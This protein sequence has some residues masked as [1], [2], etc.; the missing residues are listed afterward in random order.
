[1][2]ICKNEFSGIFHSN[3]SL[4]IPHASNEAQG[5]YQC[6]ATIGSVGLMASRK[7]KVQVAGLVPS[8]ET[9][10]QDLRVFPHQTA[11][12]SC[13][14]N[15]P[16]KYS[17]VWLKDEKP[18]SMD[19]S[20]MVLMPSGSLE[21]DE[22]EF[23]DQGS[24]RCNASS[25]GIFKLSNKAVLTMDTDLGMH[26]SSNVMAPIFITKP[27]SMVV[28]EGETIVLDCAAN[29]YP[30]PWLIWL[31]DGV[32]I[33]MAE[34][35]SRVFK[36]GSGSLKI[37]NVTEKDSGNYQCRAENREDSVDAPATIHVQ[38]P[39]R[40]LKV[41]EDTIAYEKQ[42]VE[43]VCQAYGKPEPKIQWL[44]NG[45]VIT[46]NDY[47]QVV[48][49]YNLK[50]LGLMKLD[51][52]IFQCVAVNA[53]GNVQAA[54]RLTVLQP[55]DNH[56][57]FGNNRDKSKSDGE[58]RIPFPLK[59]DEDTL[60]EDYDE[61]EDDMDDDDY[62]TSLSLHANLT[63]SISGKPQKKI[64]NSIEKSHEFKTYNN[65]GSSDSTVTD[66]SGIGLVPSS[67]QAVEVI[68]TSSR[69]VTLKV[70]PPTHTNGEITSY[71]VFFR[72]EGS[73][74]ERVLN[75]SG[76]RS[77]EITIPGLQP[78][79]TY[80]FRIVANNAHGAGPSS[81][82]LIVKTET[83]VHVPS[84][85]LGINAYATSPTTI[86]V[87]WKPPAV[88][89]GAIL[90][91][92]LLFIESDSSNENH[93]LTSQQSIEVTDLNKFTEYC[94][95]V[96]AMNE[97]GMGSA[98]EEVVTRTLSDV[99]SEPPQNVTVEPG[100]S[101]SIVVRWEPPSKDG[102]NG[103]ITGYKLRYKKQNRR[104]RGERGFTV[105]AAG[106]RRLYVLSDLEKGSSY[107]VRIWAMNVNGTGP[108]TDW[109]TVET[110]KNDL[111]ETKVP[112]KPTNVIARPSSDSIRV[113]WGP[114]KDPNVMVRGYNI[115]WGKGFPYTFSE[116]LEGK[117][118]SFN[119]KNLANS[120][121]YVIAVRA[122][123]A[124]GDGSPAYVS[125]RT[126]EEP[127]N[128]DEM[129]ILPPVGLKAIVLSSSSVILH[130]TD[131]TRVQVADDRTYSVKYSWAHHSNP[132]PKFVTTTNSNCMIND[133]R[134]NTQYEF[135]VKL[136]KGRRESKWSMVVFNTTFEAI[137]SS[138]PRDLTVVPVEKNP[139]HVNLNW[140]PP[141]QA[142]GLIT[143]YVI[144]YTTDYELP[145]KDWIPQNIVG[146][147]LTAVIK[148]LEP[149]TTYYFKIQ[150][151]NS[152]GYG[153]LST[154][155]SFKTF[156]GGPS[157]SDS[158][159]FGKDGR[160]LSKII[161]IILIC[162]FVAVLCV[163]LT[164]GIICCKRASAR[165]R[166]AS[167][168]LK[169]NLKPKTSMKPPDLWIHHDQMELK[170]LE[171]SHHSNSDIGPSSSGS[172]MNTLGRNG[173]GQTTNDVVDHTN[174]LDKRTYLPSYVGGSGC[175]VDQQEK[176]STIKRT[177]IK[178]KP[179]SLPMETQPIA[180]P[181][182]TN[183]TPL[184]QSP[185]SE[186]GRPLYPRTQY[187]A[188]I[189]LD[190]TTSGTG[191]ENPYSL[192]SGYDSIG[193]LTPTASI[194]PNANTYSQNPLTS[195]TAMQPSLAS[196]NMTNID[197]NGTLGKRQQGHPLKSFSVPAPPPQSAPST[198]QQKHVVRPLQSSSPYKKVGLHGIMGTCSPSNSKLR[199][200][201]GTIEETTRL[202]PSYS[203]EELN[204]EMANLEGLMKDL[205]AITASEFEC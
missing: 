176:T 51:A 46:D 113:S 184:T 179:I 141:K 89:N 144:F 3:G 39:P 83:E 93:M 17:F 104:E 63:N 4:T 128:E 35:G 130:W 108:P 69:S 169:G 152:K 193:T 50:I 149:S 75:T 36:L 115:G 86:I 189:T 67:P 94:F 127:P 61:Y 5:T 157:S 25:L 192:Q 99:P 171:K 138:A 177:V 190:S 199:S 191:L 10:P 116:I 201:P 31:K 165:S 136:L 170:A 122:Y 173:S 28:R 100:S 139:T 198:P 62:D 70:V 107:Q 66:S 41:P 95:W 2:C 120:S 153:P 9:Q 14:M 103:I 178:P 98:S 135:S 19:S 194:L 11:H 160:P 121:E 60:S 202:Q 124:M 133:L 21:I 164:I 143:G 54:A 91:Y 118:Q 20:R 200:G 82:D 174:S 155:V 131:P 182:M 87:E 44:K 134:P 162:S 90:K 49:G 195:Q 150:A 151:R 7:A 111:D 146:D 186:L 180:Q 71:S 96:I 172:Q 183:G 119:I 197:N 142:N 140:Q 105:T 47:L 154:K 6:V 23:S 45:E 168:Y 205:N 97:N 72:Q 55:E 166:N 204:Q 161:Y 125:V 64:G 43:L 137:P 42:D 16:L 106:D 1:M 27:K 159:L 117:Q 81:E 29:G 203:T 188:H 57:G 53:A 74:R 158:T 148:G 73:Q 156:D 18:L 76:V 22:V 68:Y 52:G 65:L 187:R 26:A 92:K 77:E 102:Q 78:D 175:T 33:D 34:I 58:K 114:P 185:G 123:N 30:R 40:F 32:A 85:P 38:V 37:V 167:G 80:H 13:I 109:I 59:A 56:Q 112:D 110:F 126:R 48:N 163:A 196:S 15:G 145:E 8:L 79:R 129:T 181:V 84:A 12:F 101:T 88:T 132:R 147:K 24:Y